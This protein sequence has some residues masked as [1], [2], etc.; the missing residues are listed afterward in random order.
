M[1][2]Q[3]SK[4]KKKKKDKHREKK[5]VLNE[6]LARRRRPTMIDLETRGIVPSGYFHDVEVAM[7]DKK[8]RKENIILDL[9]NRLQERPEFSEKLASKL[10]SKAMDSIKKRNEMVD[11]GKNE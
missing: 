8:I 9:T 1:G 10:M 6:K 7:H 11:S 5:A 3:K 4:K 2:H